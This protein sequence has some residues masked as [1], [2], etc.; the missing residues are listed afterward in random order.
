MLAGISGTAAGFRV[1]LYYVVRDKLGSDV[2]M[3]G[4]AESL[5]N[6]LLAGSLA[7]LIVLIQAALA[8]GLRALHVK[9]PV[10]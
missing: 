10:A 5:A 7:F 3:L 6:L 4:A 2:A 9:T 1:T 8:A